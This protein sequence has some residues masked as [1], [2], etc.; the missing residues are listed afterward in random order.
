MSLSSPIFILGNPRSGTTLL[1]LMLA[2]HP[3]LAVPP[4]CGFALWLRER[5]GDW[6]ARD[7][8]TDRLEEFLDDLFEARKFDTWGLDRDALRE[9]VRGMKPNDYRSLV[10]SVY[11][12][13]ASLRAPL[14]TRIG[15]KNNFHIHRVADLASLFPGCVLVHIVR[16]GRDVACSYRELAA[17]RFSSEYRP[18]LPQAIGEI[19]REW[20]SAVLAPEAA[21]AAGVMSPVHTV[22]FEDLVSD[23]TVALRS[24][25]DFLGEPFSVQ[26][27]EYHARNASEQLEPSETM[28]WKR[29]TIEPLDRSVIGRHRRLL[30]EEEIADFEAEAGDALRRFGYLGHGRPSHGDLAAAA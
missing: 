11:W 4:E 5:Y 8:S 18:D 25:C 3:R 26:M 24:I 15:D 28:A 20:R 29:K 13:F 10:E 1:R 6:A 7:K 27:L 30:A 23:P 14:A 17:G 21:V 9:W 16:D 22:R 12:H 19:A 2:C